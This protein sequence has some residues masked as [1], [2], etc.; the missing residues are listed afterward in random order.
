M[1]FSDDNENSAFT[2][3]YNQI[4]SFVTESVQLN[5]SDS[6]LSGWPGQKLSISL[7]AIDELAKATGSLI[8]FDV[9]PNATQVRY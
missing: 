9:I 1:I 4:N 5:V 7:I 2:D 8:R 6:N 3:R